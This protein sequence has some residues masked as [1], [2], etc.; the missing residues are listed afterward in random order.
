MDQHEIQAAEEHSAI[1]GL[2]VQ[3]VD[4]GAVT[5]YNDI[6]SRFKDMLNIVQECF[7]EASQEPK[8]T[9]REELMKRTAPLK[10]PPLVRKPKSNDLEKKVEKKQIMRKHMTRVID[11]ALANDRRVVYVGEDVE[12]GK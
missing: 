7:A 1:S 3:A 8:L 2:C 4:K 10:A 9:D 5:S 12:H 11:E 6:A